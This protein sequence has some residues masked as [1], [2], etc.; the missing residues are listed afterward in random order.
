MPSLDPPG[1]VIPTTTAELTPTWLATVL[2]RHGFSAAVE[3]IDFRP[4]EASPLT[5]ELLRVVPRFQDE[6]TGVA[7]PLLWKRS[8]D[9]P[10]RRA[11]F[12]RGY[13]AEVHF[14]REIAPTV[15]VSA[16]RCFAAAYDD[17]SGDHVLLIEDLSPGVP[18]S[19]IDGVSP[20][21]ASRVLTELALLHSSGWTVPSSPKRPEHFA[22]LRPFVERYEPVSTPYL[23]DAVDDRAG[24]RTRRYAAEVGELFSSLSAGPQTRVHGD[25]HP[26]NVIFAASRRGRPFLVDWQG[27]SMDAPLR[28]VARFLQLGLTIDDRRRHE[29]ALL[30]GYRAQLSANGADYDPEAATRDYLIASQLQWGWAVIFFRLESTWDA[31]TR[32]AMPALVRRAAAAFDDAT[33]WLERT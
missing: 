5:S 27:S 15:E 28:D 23:S 9:D 18:G 11:A 3:S 29:E 20:D 26:G 25:A 7:P 13:A 32:A 12:Q 10:A 8:S 16:P 30:A 22:H 4:I 17:S 33:E 19:L 14:Y 2:T 24:D 31:A 21:Q 1:G 6:T